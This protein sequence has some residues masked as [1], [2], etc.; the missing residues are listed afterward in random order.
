MSLQVAQPVARQVLRVVANKKATYATEV[1]HNT[2]L[3]AV[4]KAG[5]VLHKLE[6]AG[7]LER[8][9]PS[10]MHNDD[11]LLDRRTEL[12][13]DNVK[14]LGDFRQRKWYGL[15]SSREW[16]LQVSRKD[17]CVDEYHRPLPQDFEWDVKL[18]ENDL[19]GEAID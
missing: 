16:A 1:K 10:D 6:D 13:K 14:G 19:I 17:F 3:N 12:W 2:E 4:S 11:R 7:L 9:I 15:N 8:L 5:E 18:T